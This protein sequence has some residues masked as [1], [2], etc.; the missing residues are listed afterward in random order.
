MTITRSLAELMG[1][2]IEVA[3][4]IGVGTT[5]TVVTDP[6]AAE[7]PI[8]ADVI[9][10][11]TLHEAVRAA[12]TPAMT[13]QPFV[14]LIIDDEADARALLRHELEEL[15]CEVVCASSADEGIALARTLTPDLITLDVMMPSKNGWEALCELKADAELRDIPV[16]IISVVADEGRNSGT[17]A[18]DFFDKPVTRDKLARLIPAMGRD[19]PRPRLLLIHG[20][21]VDV[22]R[23]RDLA[24]SGALELEIA[25]D[26]D[27]ADRIIGRPGGMPDLVIL[28]GAGW[29][30]AATTWVS[31]LHERHGT[32][33]VAVVVSATDVGGA[34]TALA[35]AVLRKGE[36]LASDLDALLDGYR[37]RVRPAA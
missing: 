1:W 11:A 9:D 27:A 14:V 6:R 25:L 5:F 34:P 12:R 32:L 15:H 18:V 3:S 8:S 17:G 21:D 7:V 37:S 24:E 36:D 2:T 10:S 4:E 33:L 19:A 28:D 16:A 30:E 26:K 35:A 20:G 29:N 23:Y 31:S 22:Q 13:A